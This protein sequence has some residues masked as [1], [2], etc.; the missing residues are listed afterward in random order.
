LAFLPVLIVTLLA[1]R[2][3]EAA[4]VH[5]QLYGTNGEL[6]KPEGRLVDAGYAGYHTG[7]DPL[8]DVA[9]PS[10]RVTDFGAKPNDDGDDTQAFLDAIAATNDCVLLVPAG[11][12]VI[13]QRLEIKKSHFVLRGEG[14]GKTTLYFPKSLGSLYGGNWSFSGGLVTVS[15]RDSGAV[16]ATVTANAARGATTLAV[17]ATAGI[18]A[19]DWVRVVEADKEG[20]LFKALYGGMHPGNARQDGGQEVFHH[21]SRVTAVAGG[22]ITLERPLPFQVDTAWTPQIRAVAPSTREVGIERL[23]LEMAG[24]KYP[25]HFKEEGYNALYFDG[26]YDS[27]V[28]DVTILNA[29]YG[30]SFEKS[31]FCT[32]SGVVLDATFDRGPLIGHHGLNASRG[33]D[34]LF[35]GFD[36][37]KKYV[38][39]LT[40]DGYAMGTVFA[41]GKG[42][43]LNMD[44]H[45]RAPYGTLWT[46]LDLGKASRA[47]HSG[48]AGNRMPHTAAYTTVWNVHGAAP[49]GLPASGFGPLMNLV[50]VPGADAKAA[51][52]DYVVEAIPAEKLCQQDLHAAMLA[53]RKRPAGAAP[54]GDRRP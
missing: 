39:D 30:V 42:V 34:V 10:K 3:G 7:S 35:T 17:S 32:A 52:A 29:D 28:R 48:G 24:S 25:G 1:A 43:D 36:V 6:W 22:R 14:A 4:C 2:Q 53:R 47:F 54:R 8:P 12:Y 19:G 44:H 11:R 18:K 23:T 26:A 16:L 20:S 9:G 15:G 5:S 37:R 45:G 46:N 51:P 21:H 41:G 40:V 50:A 13:S 27:W 31:F 33:A 38:H 49:V